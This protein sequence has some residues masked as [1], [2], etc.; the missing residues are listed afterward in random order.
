VFVAAEHRRSGLA[1]AVAHAAREHLV[2]RYRSG[3]D[4]RG[5]GILFEVESEILKR[6]LPQAIWPRTGFAFIGEDARGSHIR[7]YYF[8]G[9][10]APEP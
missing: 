10:L 2:E 3:I 8:P 4:P 9:A 6:F 1:I 5:I 7:V